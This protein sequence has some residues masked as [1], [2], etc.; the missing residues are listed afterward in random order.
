MCGECHTKDTLVNRPRQKLL[1]AATPPPTHAQTHDC[2]TE[3]S[4]GSVRLNL[5]LRHSPFLPCIMTQL[6]IMQCFQSI[7]AESEYQPFLSKR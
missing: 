6:R 2:Y 5:S 4:I 3:A 1:N 7:D